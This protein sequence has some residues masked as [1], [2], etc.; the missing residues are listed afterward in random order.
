MIT[1]QIRVD[2]DISN[3]LIHTDIPDNDSIPA[4]THKIDGYDL[5]ITC[6]EYNKGTIEEKFKQL[7]ENVTK[8]YLKIPI[9]NEELNNIILALIKSSEFDREIAINIKYGY[10]IGWSKKHVEICEKFL[11]EKLLVRKILTD[12]IEDINLLG[13]QKI[14]EDACKKYRLIIKSIHNAVI[15]CGLKESIGWNR[16]IEN[17]LISYTKIKYDFQNNGNFRIFINYVLKSAK[18]ILNCSISQ[19]NGNRIII[20]KFSQPKSEII[21]YLKNVEE[22]IKNI[23][24][25]KHHNGLFICLFFYFC[26]AKIN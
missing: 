12:D 20:E 4:F 3:L 7:I 15:I 8:L 18:K 2:D 13:I 24:L 1:F 11:T 10:L 22:S 25:F 9:I 21:Y 23:I 26:T 19:Q 6:D 17:K 14:N 16:I 5:K